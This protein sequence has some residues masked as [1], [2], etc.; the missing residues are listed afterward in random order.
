ML[1]E[2]GTLQ[3][4]QM[5]PLE[6]SQIFQPLNSMMNSARADRY[7]HVLPRVNSIRKES[8]MFPSIMKQSKSV[9]P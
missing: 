7:Q 8:T 9:A 5:K 1:N 4:S 2:S 3:S 6:Y